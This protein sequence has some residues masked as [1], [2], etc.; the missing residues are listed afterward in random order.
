MT[1]PMIAVGFAVSVL[2]RGRDGFARL[3]DV[4]AAE[5][6][7]VDGPRP[8]PRHVSGSLTVDRLTFNY[9]SR[10]VLQDVS[11]KVTP[12]RSLAVVGRTGSGKTTLAML[13]ARLLPTP[14]GAVRIDGVD[15]CDL[16]LASL[17]SA[18]GYAQQDAFLFS[19]TVSR[20]IGFSFDDP[21]GPA[22]QARIRDAAGEAQVL[23]ETMALSDGFDTVG[24]ESGVQVSGGLKQ[25]LALAGALAW[26]PKILILD[27]PMSAVDAKTENA[28]LAAIERQAALR[29]ILLV[30]HRV[31]AAARCDAIVVLDAGRVVE[32]GTHDEL[33]AHG[34]IYAAFAEEQQMA[35]EL[36]EMAETDDAASS[37]QQAEAS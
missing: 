26:E 4:F 15:V 11:F 1:W 5:P 2:Q 9:G 19:T 18:I 33:V 25:R 3:R 16:P 6:E 23:D 8:A 27:D 36:E 31:S 12:G 29:T 35:T 17:R 21:D 7:V 34:G 10:A 32:Q 24:G 30:T 28:I 20:N 22:A 13:L 14:A 37:S